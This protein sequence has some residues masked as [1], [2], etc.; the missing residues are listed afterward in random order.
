MKTK[1]FLTA[2]VLMV[3]TTA[4]YASK[5]KTAVNCSSMSEVGEKVEKILNKVP[6]MT[7]GEFKNE[8]MTNVYFRFDENREMEIIRVR[9]GN[10]EI[11]KLVTEKLE[12]YSITLA[13]AEAGKIYL[14]PVRYIIR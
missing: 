9:C 7:Q 5:G 6:E 1:L 10:K 4:N 2:I 11:E 12:N 14:L 8:C 13:D 3:L